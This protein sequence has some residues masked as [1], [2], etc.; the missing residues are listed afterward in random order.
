MQ[1]GSSS[2]LRSNPYRYNARRFGDLRRLSEEAQRAEEMH[3]MY[4]YDRLLLHGPVV[5]SCLE[6]G[7]IGRLEVVR[8]K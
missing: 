3:Y 4:M 8:Y 2:N 6:G 7:E 5:Q 1:S